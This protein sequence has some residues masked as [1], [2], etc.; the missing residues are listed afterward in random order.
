M[1]G[2][3]P[4]LPSF[5]EEADIYLPTAACPLRMSDEGNLDRTSHL[6]SALGRVAPGAPMSLAAVREDL[7]GAA[8]RIGDRY[9]GEYAGTDRF[10]LSAVSVNDDLIWRFRPTLA[11]LFASAGF[12][13]LS[14][15]SS[16]GALLL[17]RA[18]ARRR[19]VAMQIALGAWRGRLLQ[20][21]VTECLLLTISGAAIGV[22][23]ARASL[24]PLVSLAA[25][26]H[27][28]SERDSTEP[29]GNHIRCDA[30]HRH[31][32]GVWRHR[33][34]CRSPEAVATRRPCRTTRDRARPVFRTLT[35]VQIAVSFALLVGAG[36][37]FRSVTNLQRVDTGLRHHDLVTMRVSTDFIKYETAQ[38]GPTST[39]PCCARCAV[40]RM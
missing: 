19:G 35:I 38:G 37:T 30:S 11:V 25:Q 5:P 36:L 20:Q 9:P 24:P 14:L 39:N 6:V 2:V 15:C 7:A 1:V 8:Q 18:V 17:A 16:I 40:C 10:N 22:V 13:V 21:F 23:F 33:A 26:V 29:D 32:T 27:V 31:R 3:L 4:P 12:L 28:P 34:R